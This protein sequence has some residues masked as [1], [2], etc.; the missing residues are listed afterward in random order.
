MHQ[1]VLLARLA[2]CAVF[3]T[4]AVAKYRD[5]H[6]VAQGLA[7]FGV[8][9]AIAP[10][11][12]LALAASEFAVAAA[13]VF[14]TTAVAGAL[15]ASV[16]LAVFTSV[17]VVNLV[18][19]RRPACNCFGAG[20]RL[21]IGWDTVARNAALIALATFVAAR[22]ADAPLI[23]T[24]AAVLNLARLQ[25]AVTALALAVIALLAV[26]ILGL[27]QLAQQQGRILLRL[28]ALEHPGAS[29]AQPVE[30]PPFA[31][32]TV[33]GE[34]ESLASLGASGL[35]VLLLFANP[36][37]GPCLALLPEVARWQVEYASS[38]TI[39]ILSEGT[40]AD[41]R[42]KAVPGLQRVLLQREREVAIAYQAYGTPSAVLID[43]GRIASDVAQGA[44]AIRGL[45]ADFFDGRPRAA[46]AT[47][48]PMPD[49]VLASQSGARVD[50]RD[51]VAANDATVLL[52]WNPKCGF[53]SNMIDDIRTW[54]SDRKD[55]DPQLALISSARVDEDADAPLTSLVLI[56]QDAHAASAFGAGGT[57]MAVRID[58]QGAITSAIVAGRDSVLALLH[59]TAPAR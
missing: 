16:L 26:I 42:S 5:R 59:P 57:P 25:P 10:G 35:P 41:N 14:D 47:G 17:V 11:V 30:A 44:D 32:A 15:G 50:L 48:D 43:D 36:S 20:N 8:P 31:L 1:I 24:T 45:V 53:C 33:D 23:P 34:T 46:L 38:L 13:L 37:C 19:G 27:W 28:E 18:R 12:T 22:A 3:A 58:A 39:A 29:V 40:A 54:E 21:P 52:F 6:G 56:D 51:V 2:L 55:G 7:G 4:A 9:E 49:V